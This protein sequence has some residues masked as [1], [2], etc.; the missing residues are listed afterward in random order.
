MFGG[1]GLFLLVGRE[2]VKAGDEE[3]LRG[4]SAG[5]RPTV[6]V[7]E[8]GSLRRV[9]LVIARVLDGIG[10]LYAFVDDSTALVAVL[11]LTVDDLIL[12]DRAVN[13]GERRGEVDFSHLTM[14]LFDPPRLADAMCLFYSPRLADAMRW[15]Y[16][17]YGAV[18][19]LAADSL[20]NN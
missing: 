3:D 17:G 16:C 12:A 1:Y 8:F 2:E 14:M 13:L 7:G 15:V 18:S 19:V 9:L 20:T 4:T 6:E 5:F 11:F 10:F